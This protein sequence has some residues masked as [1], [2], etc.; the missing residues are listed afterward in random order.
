MFWVLS[1][2]FL[3]NGKAAT[4]AHANADIAP[5]PT[6]AMSLAAVSQRLS[7]WGGKVRAMWGGAYAAMVA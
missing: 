1:P 5:T 4:P 2:F 7:G 6:G 3:K